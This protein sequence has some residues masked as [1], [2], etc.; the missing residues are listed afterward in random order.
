MI[1]RSFVTRAIIATRW[2]TAADCWFTIWIESWRRQIHCELDGIDARSSHT[3]RCQKS[4]APAAGG[5]YVDPCFVLDGMD[6]IKMQSLHYSGLCI[7]LRF[8][9]IVLCMSAVPNVVTLKPVPVCK[10]RSHTISPT[11][12]TNHVIIDNG[13]NYCLIYDKWTVSPL[14]GRLLETACNG[15]TSVRAAVIGR[16]RQ[17]NPV[18]IGY[19][20]EFGV[21]LIHQTRFIDLTECRG[22]CCEAAAAAVSRLADVARICNRD[23]M[24]CASRGRWP[25]PPGLPP[26]RHY[27]PVYI[28]ILGL[29]YT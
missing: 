14:K 27:L 29:S 13:C 5:A 23:K 4:T 16:Q 2:D 21:C 9:I 12:P 10:R 3:T 7:S 19:C 28:A 17:L 1:S 15:S 20:M 25:R 11:L 26:S 18:G 22:R 24:P 6:I 8:T